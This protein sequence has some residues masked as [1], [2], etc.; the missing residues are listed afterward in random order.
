MSVPLFPPEMLNLFL[1]ELGLDIGYRRSRAALLVRTL[2]NRQ[3]YYKVSSHLFSISTHRSPEPLNALLN[4]LNA[5]SYIAR[6]IRS[7]AVENRLDS[8]ECLSATFRQLY[9]L[10]KFRWTGY[11][12]FP[13]DTTITAITSSLK[14]HLL[15]CAPLEGIRNFLLSFSACR[16]LVTQSHQGVV[17]ENRT[18]VTVKF[19]LLIIE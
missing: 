18:R 14:V 8:V 4:I 16:H 9:H 17:C 6:L 5:H 11:F 7:F 19:T 3:F 2:V 15:H 10:Q 1:Y 12:A 13:D